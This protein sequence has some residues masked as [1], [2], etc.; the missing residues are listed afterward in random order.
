M[1]FTPNTSRH[2][3]IREVNEKATAYPTA[4][5]AEEIDRYR[6]EV[7]RVEDWLNDVNVRRR[8]VLLSGPSSSGKTTTA[9]LLCARLRRDGV[10]AHVVSLDDFYRGR[11]QAPRLPDGSYD[12]ETPEALDLPLLAS[13]I[14]EL[15]E[16]GH[17]LLPQFDFPSGQPKAERV[18]LT[19][20]QRS[21]VIF[22]GIHALH[23]HLREQLPK[24]HV[25]RLLIHPHSTFYDGEEEIL[26]NRQIRLVRRM[27]RDERHR[28]TPAAGTLTMWPGV[29][30]GEELY[31]FPHADCAD[32]VI[33]T[34]HA[35]EPCM[36]AARA[37]P[38]LKG[39]P[40][41]HPRYSLVSEIETALSKFCHMSPEL[42]PEDAI[43][44]EFLD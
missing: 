38:L 15:L 6:A 43:L 25:K 12:Y 11:G 30:R 2:L 10:D 36:F 16:E 21:V 39:I 19:L 33:D 41:D 23:P 27:V 17:T 32:M 22:E 1:I 3:Q 13:C 8:V 29:V 9:N 34:T 24:K 18:P 42:L 35:F 26:S 44:R 31:L 37:L 14:R 28:G 5:V 4:F 40:Q 7:S 20:S